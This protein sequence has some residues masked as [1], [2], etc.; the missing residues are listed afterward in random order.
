[1]TSAAKYNAELPAGF[2]QKLLLVDGH[3]Y[4]YRAYFAIRHL[5]SPSGEATNA[6]YGFV[7]A[8]AR[9]RA[10]LAP[11]HWAVV[12]DGGLAAD[13]VAAWPD[14]KAQRPPIPDSLKSQIQDLQR[15]LEANGIPSVCEDGVEAD[16]RIA[17]LARR[18]ADRGWGVVIASSDKDFMQLVSGRIN[19]VNPGDK[20]EK[21]WTAGDVQAKTGVVPEQVVDWLSLVGDTVDNI[22]GAP[23]IGPKS[24]SEL[25]RQFG[26]M[27]A[28]LERLAEVKSERFRSSLLSCRSDLLRNQELIRLRE[29]LPTGGSLD[30]FT[31]KDAEPERLR[32]FYERW[33]FKSLLRELDPVLQMELV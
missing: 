23:G 31:V 10:A 3:A 2:T 22:P 13:R 20:A 5:T 29:D 8:L 14:Y 32:E 27:N 24:A 19:L 4:A 11:T 6:I 28:L 26:S 18:A 1:M 21:L 30:T 17:T 25:L 7:K 33:G 9:L 15:Y 16:D 12:W